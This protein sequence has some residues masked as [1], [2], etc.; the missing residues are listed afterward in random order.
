MFGG[1]GG[2]AG[3]VE[4]VAEGQALAAL[5]QHARIVGLG[6]AR[7]QRIVQVEVQAIGVVGGQQPARGPDVGVLPGHGVVRVHG[8]LRPLLA[9]G[10][11]DVVAG[12]LEAIGGRI[13]AHRSNRPLGHARSI[14]V[15]DVAGHR[16]HAGYGRAGHRADATLAV[17]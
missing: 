15:V 6:A 16:R 4:R 1:G 13:A 3:A 7:A 10:P 12:G 2:G 11:E 8:H 17:V 14:G 5:F 9:R